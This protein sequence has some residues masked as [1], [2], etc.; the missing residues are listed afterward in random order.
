MVAHR[1]LGPAA[2]TAQP[3]VFHLETRTRNYR[4]YTRVKNNT[5]RKPEKPPVAD[6]LT[7]EKVLLSEASSSNPSGVNAAYRVQ[8]VELMQIFCVTRRHD[9]VT[10]TL[11]L[12]QSA[13][14]FIKS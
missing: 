3:G 5:I 12:R 10:C 11:L 1:A 2:V 8:H 14:H 13:E 7:K 4:N 9:W 6:V